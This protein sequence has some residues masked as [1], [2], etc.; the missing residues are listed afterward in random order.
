MR[1]CGRCGGS[2]FYATAG[3]KTCAK[4]RANA[5]RERNSALVLA[6]KAAYRA[7]NRGKLISYSKAYYSTN[8]QKAAEYYQ[9]NNEAIKARNRAYRIADPL[10][11]KEKSAK[12]RAEHPEKV[13]ARVA[14]YRAAN[15][16]T[17]R[18]YQRQYQKAHPES[19]RLHNQNRRA[20]RK[21]RG[22]S[23]SKGLSERLFKLQRGKCACCGLPLGSDYHLDHIFPL[24]LGGTNTD[25]NI[26]LLRALCNSQKHAK[27][28]VEFMQQRGFLL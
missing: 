25:R 22:G 7:K 26:Q 13:R 2:E 8:K 28:P 18:E 17:L 21:S 15:R 24:A 12:Y 23:L 9:R 14:E 20:A 27:H 5:Y 1:T 16:Q 11:F 10:R 3:C 6:K 19:Y 4:A